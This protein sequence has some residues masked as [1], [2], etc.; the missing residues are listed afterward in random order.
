MTKSTKILAGLGVVAALGVAALPLASYAETVSGNVQLEVEVL[1]AI[2]MT[3]SGNNDSGTPHAAF[4]AVTVETGDDVSAYYEY[5]GTNHTYALTSDGT[6]GAGKTYYEK[7]TL[8]SF[9]EIDNV[10]APSGIASKTLD[11]HTIVASQDTDTSSSYVSI[12]P[13]SKVEGDRSNPGAT[14]NNFGSIITVYTNANAGYTLSVKDFDANTDLTHTSGEF[15]IQARSGSLT[16]GTN[17]WNYDVTRFGSHEVNFVPTEGGTAINDITD[18]AITA[19]DVEIDNWT[20][21]T[22]NGRVTIVDYNVATDADQATG[23][24]TDT[25]VYTATTR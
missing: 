22:S 18:Q 19:S 20:A 24:Y 14:P 16:A 25:I 5:D 23:T 21:K 9:G 17:G 8:G 4:K 11:G 2:A 1:P 3:I 6:A 12:L 15:H 13:Y 7:V 10:F